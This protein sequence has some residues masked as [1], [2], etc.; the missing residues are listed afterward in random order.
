MNF[1]KN[2][3]DPVDGSVW[4]YSSCRDGHAVP[5]TRYVYNKKSNRLQE[6]RSE[7]YWDPSVYSPGLKK[8]DA[9]LYHTAL[10]SKLL[11]HYI[12][13]EFVHIEI[14]KSEI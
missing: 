11:A 2:A 5:G 12:S 6:S 3:L 8:A 10:V 4:L 14:L 7:A 13:I 9:L 1:I